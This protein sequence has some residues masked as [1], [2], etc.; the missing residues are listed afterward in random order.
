MGRADWPTLSAQS[1][2]GVHGLQALLR[3]GQVQGVLDQLHLSWKVELIPP[4]TLI[5]NNAGEYL[6]VLGRSWN[7]VVAIAWKVQIHDLGEG[8]WFSLDFQSGNQQ[9]A[10]WF[11]LLQWDQ[12]RVVPTEPVSP[13]GQAAL[14]GPAKA[15]AAILL[16]KTGPLRGVLEHAALNCFVG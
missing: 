9:P 15:H 10:I 3:W 11:G 12:V 13:L 2:Q 8:D 1:S 4:C 16:R 14:V 7:N 6:F 5:C